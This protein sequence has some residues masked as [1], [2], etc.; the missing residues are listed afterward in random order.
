MNDRFRYRVFDK[1]KNNYVDDSEVELI[2]NND[3]VLLFGNWHEDIKV[4]EQDKFIVEQC[5]GFSDKN[6][7]LIYDGDIVEAHNGTYGVVWCDTECGWA[8]R[9]RATHRMRAM[10]C[11]DFDELSV[12]SNIHEQS[13]QKDK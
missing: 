6:G 1:E 4:V 5:T 11:F 9:H 12:F 13:E 8:L 2:L 7:K 10:N 3:G